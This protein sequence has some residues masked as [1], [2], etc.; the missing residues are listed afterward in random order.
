MPDTMSPEIAGTT[1]PTCPGCHFGCSL[2]AYRCGRGKGF[3][4]KWQA[5]EAVPE[6]G[7][8]PML[9]GGTD[10]R[11]GKGAPPVDV[12]V[13]HA[14]NIMANKLQNRHTEAAER[15]VLG[16]VAR[17]GGFFAVNLL[18]KRAL[19]ESP[20]LEDAIDFLVT[21]GLL[22]LEDEPVAGPVLRITEEGR[23]RQREWNAEHD[24][25]TAEFLAPL[26]EDEQDQL[27]QLLFRLI[28][29]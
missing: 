14:L 9:R 4:G 10:G 27:A 16:S 28:M 23:A 12:R 15:K 25:A 24:A 13:M 26:T 29:N 19:V 7:K 2:D 21:E 20:Q 22:V 18:G 1:A 8:P 5:G 11:G 17:Q 6:R 3:H